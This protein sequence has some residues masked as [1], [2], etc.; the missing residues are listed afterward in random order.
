VEDLTRSFEDVFDALDMDH[1]GGVA[2]E[3]YRYYY[4]CSGQRLSDAGGNFAKLDLNGDGRISREEF[5]RLCTDFFLG[6]DPQA[7]GNWL[8]GPY[9]EDDAADLVVV[10]G[11]SLSLRNEVV[12]LNRAAESALEGFAAKSSTD[13][14][15]TW[16]GIEGTISGTRFDHRVRRYLLNEC[17]VPRNELRSRR[18]GQ[19]PLS[20]SDSARS[21]EDLVRHFDWRYGARRA[22]LFL[23]DRGL[24]SGTNQVTPKTA[25]AVDRV[26]DLAVQEKVTI[27]TYFGECDSMYRD[28]ILSEYVRLARET[29]GLTMAA[30]DPDMQ[31]P[32]FL[33]QVL[34]AKP[35]TISSPEA[36]GAPSPAPSGEPAEH[37]PGEAAGAASLQPTSSAARVRAK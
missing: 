8:F 29:G 13:L 17:G 12:A 15:T 20:H 31:L 26:R 23:G 30:G 22:V 5:T 3:D 6:D 24:D 36:L 35:G 25:T 10:V 1:D 34:N 32:G 27:H 9:E 4:A 37:R 11:S 7:P 14:R 19:V 21:L 33:E 16:L 28:K 2:L 18:R